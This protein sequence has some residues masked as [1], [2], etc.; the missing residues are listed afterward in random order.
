MVALTGEACNAASTCWVVPYTMRVVT[1]TTRPF[2]RSLTTTAYLRQVR[3]R[4][5][6]KVRKTS[7]G[8]VARW[9][10]PLPIHFQQGFAIMRQLVTGDTCPGGRC[11]GERNAPIG[12]RFQPK[13]QL[14][15]GGQ[16]AVN[17]HP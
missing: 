11:Q 1:S 14:S 7:S 10:H 2:S 6:P 15:R 4:D 12:G 9:L 8:S 13:N 17:D 16:G 3:R 5:T